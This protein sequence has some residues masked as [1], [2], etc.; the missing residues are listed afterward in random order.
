[1]VESQNFPLITKSPLYTII[2]GENFTDTF[3]IKNENH[4]EKIN[5]VKDSRESKETIKSNTRLFYI[6]EGKK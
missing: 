4:L 5:Y 2:S 6:N 1:M 3:F